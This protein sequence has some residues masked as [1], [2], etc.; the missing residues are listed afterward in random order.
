[1]EHKGQRF[2]QSCGMPLSDEL[3]GTERD[4]NASEDYCRYCYE[5]GAFQADCTM[6][7]MIDFCVGPMVQANPGMSPEA[8]RGAMLAFFPKL[9]RWSAE[10]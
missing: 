3:R 1:M 10:R 6:E 9:K 8:A 2:C 5:N 4:G 7:E